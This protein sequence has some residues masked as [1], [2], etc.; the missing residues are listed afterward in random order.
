MV[1]A[2]TTQDTGEMVNYLQ[3]ATRNAAKAAIYVPF[4]AEITAELSAYYDQ[5]QAERPDYYPGVG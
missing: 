1:T 2:A 3:I 4:L 5:D